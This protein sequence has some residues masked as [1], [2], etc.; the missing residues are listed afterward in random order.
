MA[1]TKK[2]TG[3]QFV[4]DVINF[5]LKKFGIDY[6]YLM[7]LPEWPDDKSKIDPNIEYRNDWFQRYCFDSF[8]EFLSWKVYFF[9]HWKDYAPKTNWKRS[10]VE[11][12]FEWFNL[13]Y[14][15]KTN[16]EF[17]LHKNRKKE[18]DVYAQVYGKKKKKV[19]KK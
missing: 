5:E 10:T 6:D 1:Y 17:E 16:Y 12:G 9:K 13:M 15:L 4:K 3:K 19:K 2:I 14:G 7:S 11:R 18:L 8:D